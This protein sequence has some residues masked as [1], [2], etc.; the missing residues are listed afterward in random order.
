MQTFI[1]ILLASIGITQAPQTVQELIWDF[2]LIVFG[3]VVI[4]LFL[5]FFFGLFKTINKW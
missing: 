1:D 2:I 4:K 3:M 5:T